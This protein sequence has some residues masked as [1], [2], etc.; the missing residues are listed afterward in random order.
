METIEKTLFV[1]EICFDPKARPLKE[2]LIPPLA[3]S[4]HEHGM[5]KL[6]LVR[7]CGEGRPHVI[8]D[9]KHRFAA[10]QLLVWEEI[11]CLVTTADEIECRQYALKANLYQQRLTALEQCED[12]AELCEIILKVRP[13]DAPSPGGVQPNDMGN[14]Y[15]SRQL[16][17]SEVTIR[18]SRK[19]ASLSPEAK[20]RAIETGIDDHMD[21]LLQLYNSE[22]ENRRGNNNYTPE[23][24]FEDIKRAEEE[25]RRYNRFVHDWRWFSQPLMERFLCEEVFR[26][27]RAHWFKFKTF[28]FGS[29][30]ERYN[31]ESDPPIESNLV[32][33]AQ[34]DPM[35]EATPSTDDAEAEVE[36]DDAIAQV[37]ATDT[38]PEAEAHD[39]PAMR[40]SPAPDDNS[41]IQDTPPSAAPAPEQE[42]EFADWKRKPKVQQQT[43]GETGVADQGDGGTGRRGNFERTI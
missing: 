7:D 19:V 14:R 2:S 43:K 30:N 28:F 8:V 41:S 20:K 31:Y 23:S 11:R 9:G 16:G 34:A 38:T 35:P 39:D 21:A 37:D 15:C 3:K 32:T 33:K 1:D 22:R 29:P 5:Q 10:V 12:I 42:E 18:R 13:N 40:H 36:M 4:I 26:C 24:Y 17:I 6:I 27:S 25:K